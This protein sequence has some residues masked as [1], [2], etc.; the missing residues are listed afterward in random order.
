DSAGVTMV[1]V[2]T[3]IR[4]VTDIMGQISVASSEQSVGVSQIGEAVSQMDKATQQNA[5]L[6]EQMAAAAS[7]L[8]SLADDQV[9]AVAV[10]KLPRHLDGHLALATSPV[11]RLQLGSN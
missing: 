9:H 7:G 11:A 8:K 2:V 3:S 10:F 4:Q 5:A 6:V 1:E